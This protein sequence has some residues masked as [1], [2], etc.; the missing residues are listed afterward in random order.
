MTDLISEWLILSCGAFRPKKNTQ[1]IVNCSDSPV[2][3]LHHKFYDFGDNYTV[4]SSGRWCEDAMS[5]LRGSR[6]EP[7]WGWRTD[8]ENVDSTSRR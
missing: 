1:G 8:G 4:S 5:I 2:S 3:A 7:R 6:G